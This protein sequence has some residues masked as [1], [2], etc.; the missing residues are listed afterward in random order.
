MH[1]A[2]QKQ[3]Y[4][5]LQIQQLTSMAR[6]FLTL[7]HTFLR[8]AYGFPYFEARTSSNRAEDSIS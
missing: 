3:T 4:K 1:S 7:F 2:G 5:A 8:R 6:E